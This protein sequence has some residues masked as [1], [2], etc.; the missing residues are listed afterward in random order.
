MQ[1]A[2]FA[3]S[4]TD[5]SGESEPEECEARKPKQCAEGC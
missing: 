2:C 3:E 5:E 1:R 4:D